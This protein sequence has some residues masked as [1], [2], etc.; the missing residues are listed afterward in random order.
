MPR[1]ACQVSI[2]SSVERVDSDHCQKELAKIVRETSR[3]SFKYS[4]PIFRVPGVAAATAEDK[5][6]FLETIADQINSIATDVSSIETDISMLGV[7][8]IE[9][10]I[11][12]L[13]KDTYDIKLDIRKIL[14]RLP[15]G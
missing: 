6:D 15:S 14:D 10:R 13:G 9:R 4:S 7:D 1:T 3:K 12:E 11:G 5:E 8:D 2:A